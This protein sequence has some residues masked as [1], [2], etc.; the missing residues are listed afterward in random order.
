VLSH[1][2]TGRFFFSKT[3]KKTYHHLVNRSLYCFNC[4]TVSIIFNCFNQPFC[5]LIPSLLPLSLSLLPLDSPKLMWTLM[6]VWGPVHLYSF[7]LKSWFI[8]S[9]DESFIWVILIFFQDRS[10]RK[11]PLVN[12]LFDRCIFQFHS[13]LLY[14]VYFVLIFFIWCTIDILPSLTS[15]SHAY[16]IV[17]CGPNMVSEPEKRVCLEKSSPASTRSWVQSAEL[18]LKQSNNKNKKMAVHIVILLPWRWTQTDR[19]GFLA[20]QPDYL[21]SF[22]SIKKICLKKSSS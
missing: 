7:S 16:T 19:W 6:T 9:I 5:I 20:N 15:K 2:R 14:N 13:T 4:S 18:I 1:T 21:S 12:V 10:N 11:P 22:R 8:V 17:F 3:G